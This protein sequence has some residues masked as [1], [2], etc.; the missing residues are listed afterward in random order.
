MRTQ[1]SHES[2]QRA[3]ADDFAETA[4]GFEHAGY[5]FTKRSYY[6]RN[7]DGTNAPPN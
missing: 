5:G 2:R 3:E 7:R 1:R 6:S 4:L